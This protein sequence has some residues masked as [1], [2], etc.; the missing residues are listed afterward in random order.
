MHE[1][2]DDGIVALDLTRFGRVNKETLRRSDGEAK[3]PANEPTEMCW[4][5]S[6]RSTLNN[7]TA[8]IWLVCRYLAANLVYVRMNDG[9]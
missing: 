3:V 8:K 7:V 5:E 6:S 4:K 1:R 9:M 2:S